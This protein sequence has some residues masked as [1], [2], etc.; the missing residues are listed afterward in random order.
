[1]MAVL[2][3][4]PY[5]EKDQ[6]KALGAWWNNDLKKW[7]VPSEKN[8]YKFKRWISASDDFWILCNHLYI[9]EAEQTCYKCKGNT[10]VIGYGIESYFHFSEDEDSGVYYNKGGEV[11]IASHI[12]PIP[13]KI[14]AYLQN[15]F[16]YKE[17]YSK[18]AG[19]TYLANCC[20]NCDI[21][22]GDYFLFHEVDSP[23]WIYNESDAA[24]LRL[25]KIPL[26]YDLVLDYVDISFGTYD[27][28]IKEFGE[29]TELKL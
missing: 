4:V 13:D 17:R 18:F 26:E 14:L 19:Y 6:A 24:K 7:Y 8:Y 21:L 28:L 23:F 3:N 1:M 11:H 25:Y 10:Q 20:D 22:Q 2:L 12:A 15:N 9:V 29:T 5:A 16:N 27:F